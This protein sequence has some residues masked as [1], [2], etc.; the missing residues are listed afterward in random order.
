MPCCGAS[1]ARRTPSAEQLHKCAGT[2]Q[3]ILHKLH[4]I[5]H[6]HQIDPR[7]SNGTPARHRKQEL[8]ML[9]PLL[10][11]RCCWWS[12]LGAG[13]CT[14]HNS[15]RRRT[16][17]QAETPLL[18]HGVGA[19]ERNVCEADHNRGHHCDRNSAYVSEPSGVLRHKCQ[20][21]VCCS[22]RLG[23]VVSEHTA[24]RHVENVRTQG[25]DEGQRGHVEPYLGRVCQTEKNRNVGTDQGEVHDYAE[26]GSEDDFDG[27]CGH[28][29]LGN[30]PIIRDI[31]QF[32]PHK[33]PGDQHRQ[34][35]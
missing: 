22:H 16:R 32:L 10:G 18:A 8:Q 34:S 1:C 25:G 27:P 9:H 29:Q 15:L 35:L 3:L 12:L 33:R 28:Q 4:A 23:D 13:M 26:Q 30:H 17:L 2:R 11:R 31:H 14:R 20:L 19:L 21:E 24:L 6:L 7:T 5:W